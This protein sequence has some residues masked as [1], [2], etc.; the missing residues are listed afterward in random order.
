MIP[1]D[2]SVMLYYAIGSSNPIMCINNI[3]SD[4][5]LP[6]QGDATQLVYSTINTQTSEQHS[7]CN[8]TAKCVSSKLKMTFVEHLSYT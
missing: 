1:S 8:I 5:V 7:Q 6:S 4:P 2:H 3:I